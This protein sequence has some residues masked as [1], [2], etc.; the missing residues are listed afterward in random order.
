[1]QQA[2]AKAVALFS[3]NMYM[4]NFHIDISFIYL[5]PNQITVN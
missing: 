1:M 3:K 2:Q 5:K 4:Y